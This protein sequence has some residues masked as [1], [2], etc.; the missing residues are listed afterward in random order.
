[1]VSSLLQPLRPLEMHQSRL[2]FNFVA[3]LQISSER[4]SSYCFLVKLYDMAV[5]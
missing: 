2:V 3:K 1:M 4:H 5:S